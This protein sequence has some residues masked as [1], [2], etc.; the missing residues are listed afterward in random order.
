[1]PSRPYIARAGSTVHRALEGFQ[2]IDLPF[3]LAVAAFGKRWIAKNS[4]PLCIIQPDFEFL[5]VFALKNASES[6]GEPTHG[7]EI[8][9]G[10]F[11]SVD[12]CP[13]TVR[14]QSARA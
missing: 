8:R 4:G 7:G 5:D 10:A 2:S 12:L 6:H 11:Q 3:G 1:V 9:R 14:Q 13:L